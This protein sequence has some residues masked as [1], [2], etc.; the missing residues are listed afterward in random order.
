MP[1]LRRKSEFMKV[2]LIVLDSVG[3][4]AAP[5]AGAYGDAGSATLPHCASAVGGLHLPTLQHMGLGNIPEILPGGLDIA[6]VPPTRAPTA[7]WGALQELSQ[8]KDTTTGHWEMAGLLIEQGFHVFPPGHPSFPEALIETFVARTGRGVLG[9][10]AAS[11]TAIIKELGAEHMASGKWIVYTSADSVFQIAAHEAIIPLDELYAG[12]RVV[13]ELCDPLMVGRVIARPFVGPDPEHF[14]RTGSR[15]DF[16]L[17]PPEPTILDHLQSYG[18]KTVT[19]G[20]LDDVFTN[21]GIDRSEHVEDNHN[22]Q[23]VVLSIAEQ[24]SSQFVFVNLIDF[25]MLY[26]HRRDADGYAAALES[27]DRFLAD[28]L[29]KLNDDDCVM[30]TADHG[31]DP[32]F[33]GT[34]HTR[35][36][37]PLLVHRPGIRGREL[38]IRKGF[39]DVGQSVA[40]LF[41]VPPMQRGVSVF[42]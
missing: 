2:F 11:G 5:D 33:S 21:R 24:S 29:S 31:N 6:G 20:K 23:Q 40:D 13:R 35:E 39:F 37:V 27:T 19:V 7:S 26:G 4:G 42:G 30:L 32:T 3:I 9:N 17:V 10:K 16:S 36:F 34:D 28:L 25:D 14:T 1:A 18:V 38:G 22:A 8:G 12:C 41:G 15:R